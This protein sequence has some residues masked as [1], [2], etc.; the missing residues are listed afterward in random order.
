LSLELRYLHPKTIL[1]TERSYQQP[2]VWVPIWDTLSGESIEE[3]CG[4]ERVERRF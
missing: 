4:L 2:R 3:T 1:D